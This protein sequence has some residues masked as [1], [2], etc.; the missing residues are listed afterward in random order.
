MVRPRPPSPARRAGTIWPLWTS[1][2]RARGPSPS[3][4]T[5]RG[6]GSQ[7]LRLLLGL[8]ALRSGLELHHPASCSARY[9]RASRGGR[10]VHSRRRR[11]IG[12]M[13]RRGPSLHRKHDAIRVRAAPVGGRADASR[14]HAGSEGHVRNAA[15]QGA[16]A[17]QRA[18][19]ALPRG[20]ALE[21]LGHGQL[22]VRARGAFI[23]PAT[24]VV[25]VGHAHAP[26][27]GTREL[28][29][30]LRVGPVKKKA[31]M[32]EGLKLQY[33]HGR[34]GRDGWWWRGLGEDEGQGGVRQLLV[35]RAVRGEERGAL[36]RP[37]AAQRQE[38][39]PF[40][41]LQGPVVS[42]GGRK[43]DPTCPECGDKY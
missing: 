8:R 33:Q 13:A 3:R 19:S 22:P 10:A 41:L 4:W 6:Q 23:K 20:A 42:V 7:L 9:S 26:R 5:R 24:D 31:G 38:H 12:R 32:S 29:V 16:G 25:L 1:P 15:R 39:P 28:L 17:R 36:L 2:C 27:V 40:P 37:D 30:S 34:R 11:S 14:V 35:R 43:S 18:G 21:G